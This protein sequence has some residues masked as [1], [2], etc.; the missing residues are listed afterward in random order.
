MALIM[1]TTKGGRNPV[2]GQIGGGSRIT[3]L[4][5]ES[6]TEMSDVHWAVCPRTTNAVEY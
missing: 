1:P 3:Q 6:F 5:I 2:H 4:F